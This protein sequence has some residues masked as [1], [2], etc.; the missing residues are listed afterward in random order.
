MPIDSQ[1]EVKQVRIVKGTGAQIAAAR[2]AQEILETDLV[3]QTDAPELVPETRTINGKS[4]ANNISLDA[5][6]VGAVASNAAI[7]G[8]TKCKITYDS[9]GLVTAGSDLGSSDITTALGY[10]PYD[11]SNPSGYTSNIGT[12]TSVNNTSPDSSGNV[13]L[14]IPSINSTNNYVPYRSSASAFSNSTLMYNSS[15]MAFTGKLHIGSTSPGSYSNFGRFTIYDNTPSQQVSSIALLNYGGGGGC[16][17]AI[18]MYNT[19]ANNGIPSGRIGILDNNSYSAYMSLQCKR[20]GGAG[21]PLVPICTLTPIPFSGATNVTMGVGGTHESRVIFDV[22]RNETSWTNVNSTELRLIGSGTTYHTNG[23]HPNHKLQAYLTYAIGDK[24]AT[25]SSGDNECFITGISS[26]SNNAIQIT[27]SSSL[28][29]RTSSNNVYLKKAFMKISDSNGAKLFVD[30]DGKVGINTV[31]PAYNLDVSGTINASTDVKVNG[32]SVALSSQIPTDTSDLTNGAGFITSSAL[33]GY[34]TETWVGQQGYI[35]GITSNDVTTALGY[36]PYNSSNPSGYITGIN[37][38]DV[39]TAL[40][41]T[42]Y[43]A[44]NPN[45]YTSNTGTVTSVNNV[46]PVGGNVTISIPTV[47]Q[48]YDGTSSNAQSGVAVKSAIDSAISSVYKPAGSVAFSSLPALSSS[49]EGYVYNVT[50][51]F[52]TTS[53]FVE[54]SGKTYPAGTNVVCIDVGSSIYKWDVLSG[55]IDLSGYVPTSRTINNKALASNIS[56]TASDVGALPDST[57]IGNAT[58][59]IQKN[60]TTI[61]T[62][63]ANA[64]SDKT[65]NVTVPT[66]TSDLTNG[67]GF[68]TGITSSDVTTALGYTPYDASNPSG[69]ISLSSLSGTSPISYNNSTGVISVSS[70]YQIPTTTQVSQIGTNTSN[71]STIN[72]KIPSQASTTN[73][74][75][76]KSFVNSSIST[77]T[78]NFIGTFNS[79]ADLEAYGGTLTNNDYAFVIGTD[80][81]GNTIYNRYKYTTATNPAEWVFEYALNNS[82]FTANQWASINSGATTTNIALAESALQSGDDVS[83]LNNDAGYITSSALSGYLQNTATGTESLTILGTATTGNQGTNAGVLSTASTYATSLGNNARASGTA[84][85]A[86]GRYAIASKT[87]SVAIGNAARA[88]AAGAIALGTQ[89]RNSEAKTLKVALTDAGDSTPAVDESTGLFTLL[90][91]AGKIPNGRLTISTSMS[92]SSTDSEI[93]SLK[94][95]YDTR[96]DIETWVGQQGYITG[97]TSSDV[98][99]ALGYTPYDAS[100]PNGYTSNVGTVTSVN[101]VNP[102]NG[103]VTL[104]IP[105]SASDVGAVDLDAS[106]LSNTGKSLISG[107]GMPSSRYTDLTLLASGSTY[108]APANGWF[109]FAK[110]SSASNQYMTM[111]VD[112]GGTPIFATTMTQALNGGQARCF[113]PVKKGDVVGVNYDL[114]GQTR[115]F[116]FVYAEGEPNV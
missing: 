37:S 63:T 29:N 2:Q 78:A 8:A 4:L 50:D 54:G 38:S 116:C 9:K 93:P 16:G 26:Y 42:P 30:P 71:I 81:Q 96:G 18:D 6:D 67:A 13:S 27:T 10:T 12:V 64:T 5:S 77:N 57:T 41:Y 55:I 61:D 53:D 32:S 105:S 22:I 86:L 70:G 66:D 100:N 19:S 110:T 87:N 3:V 91:S 1:V 80:Q 36:T 21:N 31:T 23:S 28:G 33:S 73:Q 65:I 34:A 89:A 62:F 115:R 75:A 90:T 84:S 82:S 104:S 15:A 35:T 68:I 20:S 52:T 88:T 40:G 113:L 11:S 101:N 98:T 46:S 97:I 48:S 56:L 107:L 25:S 51:S 59:T 45:G 111:Y 92:S 76:D 14:A 39:T 24:L 49:I 79:V 102:V 114:G 74:L 60:G 83:E 47:D 99:T 108:T 85:T 58:L 109:Y 95:L 72:G 106:N 17:V 7:T 69:F 43:D 103:N 112:N 44:S 94:L